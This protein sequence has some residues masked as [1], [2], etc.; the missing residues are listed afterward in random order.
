MSKKHPEC[1]L[2]NHATCKELH[3]PNLCAIV[4]KDDVC[5]KINSKHMSKDEKEEIFQKINE[6]KEQGFTHQQVADWLNNEGYATITGRGKWTHGKVG[7]LFHS[8]KK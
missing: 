4:R 3:N 6:L 7:S 8:M 2:Y 1:P 5:L